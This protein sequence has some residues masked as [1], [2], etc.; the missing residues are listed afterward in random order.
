MTNKH[1]PHDITSKCIYDGLDK[2]QLRDD[3]LELTLE[4]AAEKYGVHKYTVS[5]WKNRLGITKLDYIPQ[6]FYQDALQMTYAQLADKYQI[7]ER[8]V[9]THIKNLDLDWGMRREEKF[10]A[11][12]PDGFS[13]VDM[14]ADRDM[15]VKILHKCGYLF[16]VAPKNFNGCPRCKGEE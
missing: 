2:N 16:E 11:S 10:K 13:L 5:R 9:S 3:L 8:Q 1:R 7:S 15:P 14:Y 4:A 12:L 6:G